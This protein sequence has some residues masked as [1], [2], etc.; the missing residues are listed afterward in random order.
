MRRTGVTQLV[1]EICSKE[2]KLPNCR[3]RVGY[4]R[5][6]SPKCGDAW[7]ASTWERRRRECETCGKEFFPRPIQLRAGKGRFCSHACKGK[8]F[9]GA[10]NPSFGKPFPEEAKRKFHETM[11]NRGGYPSGPD[12]PGWKGGKTMSMGYVYIG[13][14][15]KDRRGE[16]RRVM[17]AHLGRSLNK[18]EVVHHINGIK[19][20][21]RIENLQ[22]MTRAQHLLEHKEEI[23][24]NRKRATPLT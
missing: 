19:T 10:E 20:D 15:S 13:P 18:G 5:F 14:N 17:E 12:H 11:M 1:C 16:H 2:F 4:G 23:F 7:R 24:A 8:A 22:V 9:T 3:V 21:N 6:C